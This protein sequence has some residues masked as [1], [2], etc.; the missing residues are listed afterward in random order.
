MVDPHGKG[1][2]VSVIG[3]IVAIGVVDVVVGIGMRV[4]G[5]MLPILPMGPIVRIWRFTGG[6]LTVPMTVF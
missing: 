1:I 5:M 3:M 6:G 2:A 4:I